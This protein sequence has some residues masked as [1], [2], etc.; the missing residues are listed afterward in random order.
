MSA[1]GNNSAIG[2]KSTMLSPIKRIGLEGVKGEQD[3]RRTTRRS[4]AIFTLSQADDNDPHQ[5]RS[6]GSLA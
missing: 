2:K 5:P 1:P 6:N 4:A 3:A